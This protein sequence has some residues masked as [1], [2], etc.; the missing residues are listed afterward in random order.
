MSL[1]TFLNILFLMIVILFR[2]I[3]IIFRL[4]DSY[5]YPFMDNNDDGGGRR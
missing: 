5:F 4:D 1:S 2:K 3:M